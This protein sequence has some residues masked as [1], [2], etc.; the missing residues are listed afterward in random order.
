MSDHAQARAQARAQAQ[1]H[2]APRLPGVPL[3][4][5]E[6]PLKLLGAALL[7][8][9]GRGPLVPPGVRPEVGALVRPVVVV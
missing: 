8:L 9:E 3:G 1:A 6:L 7:E 2:A 5:E 4:V